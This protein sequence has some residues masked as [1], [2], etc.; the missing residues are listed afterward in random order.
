[1][2]VV[3]LPSLESKTDPLPREM[4]SSPPPVHSRLAIWSFVVALTGMLVVQ[5]AFPIHQAVTYGRLFYANA[6]DEPSYLQYDFAKATRGLSRSSAYLVVALHDVG[7]P[8]GVQNVLFDVVCTVGIAVFVRRAFLAAGFHAGAAGRN[9]ILLLILPLLLGGADTLVQKLYWWNLNSHAI[10]WFAVPQGPY[11][12]LVRTPEPQFSLLL[13]SIAAAIAVR[14][15][16]FWPLYAVLPLLY[17]FVT[18]PVLFV[19][20]TLHGRQLLRRR[21][22]PLWLAPLTSF[23]VIGGL[24]GVYHVLFVS[25]SMKE[26]LVATRLPLLSFTG[27]LGCMIAVLGHRHCPRERR[28]LL[29]AVAVAPLVAVNE[30]VISGWLAAPHC[31]EQYMGVA[32]CSLAAVLAL[33]RR[34]V[35]ILV[36]LV[37]AAQFV[38]HGRREFA[39]QRWVVERLDWTDELF[40]ALRDDSPQVAINDVNLAMNANMLYPH[41]SS[42]A[43]GFER[44]FAAVAGEEQVRAYVSARG[45]ILRDP[46]L[47]PQFRGLFAALDTAYAFQGR[48]IAPLHLFRRPLASPVFDVTTVPSD[49]P[50]TKLRIFTLRGN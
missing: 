20:L 39:T 49:L 4:P 29:W 16:A 3:D 18:V 25:A 43:F 1:M 21:M 6:D 37:A 22:L 9:A 14:R 38:D 13:V 28:P 34:W 2:A 35:T 47:A 5:N 48:N 44:S 27:L 17:T 46:Q 41:Q 50:A 15:R 40:T 33:N 42:T 8:A 36:M 45:Q 23:V 10:E 30:Q 19:T 11:S 32:C 12:P 31:H 26:F 24:L 7:I